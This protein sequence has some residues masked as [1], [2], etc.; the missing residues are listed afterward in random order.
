ML[1]I[2]Q[3]QTTRLP[4]LLLR[5]QLSARPRQASRC[6]CCSGCQAGFFTP[7]SYQYSAAGSNPFPSYF[8][9]INL[10][11]FFYST[12]I[13]PFFPALAHRLTT[14]FS[15]HHHLAPAG[16]STLRFTH[17]ASA[18]ATTTTTTHWTKS[19][20]SFADASCWLGTAIATI[21]LALLLLRHPVSRSGFQLLF[22]FFY[23]PSIHFHHPLL[24]TTPLRPPL[25]A[26][27]CSYQ[28]SCCCRTVS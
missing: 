13:L 27:C 21:Y 22:F 3:H 6:C 12:T 4:I 9:Q 17:P 15:T 2:H 16:S 25:R 19:R 7:S 26:G 1:F 10:F 11:Y 24:T 5:C 23:S 28:A 8:A 14:N 20:R 18:T